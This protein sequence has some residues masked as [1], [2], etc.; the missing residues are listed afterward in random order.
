MKHAIAKAKTVIQAM[1]CSSTAVDTNMPTEYDAPPPYSPYFG[2]SNLNCS[3]N[4]YTATPSTSFAMPQQAESTMS[5]S[6]WLQQINPGRRLIDHIGCTNEPKI[7][8]CCRCSAQM[9][10]DHM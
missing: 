6:D 3:R 8:V 7:Y 5:V 4:S 1:E 2:S 9:I 10:S